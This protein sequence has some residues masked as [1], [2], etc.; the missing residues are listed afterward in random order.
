MLDR[1]S[2]EF[3][4]VIQ[5]LPKIQELEAESVGIENL[6]LDKLENDQGKELK[7]LYLPNNNIINFGDLRRISLSYTVLFHKFLWLN[8]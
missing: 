4:K 7:R 6:Y 1:P 5:F 2:D 3:I 8:I